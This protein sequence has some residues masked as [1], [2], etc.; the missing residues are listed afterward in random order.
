MNHFDISTNTKETE[1][2]ASSLF[3][4]MK[5]SMPEKQ[6]VFAESHRPEQWP[7]NYKVT[8]CQDVAP[9]LLEASI[10]LSGKRFRP[11]SNLAH[12][13]W[14]LP[15]PQDTSSILWQIWGERKMI[16]RNSHANISGIRTRM[17]E[18]W[19]RSH[20]SSSSAWSIGNI[21]LRAAYFS[22]FKALFRRKLSNQF[23]E[24]QHST[25]LGTFMPYR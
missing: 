15:L 21:A 11:L 8:R 19:L 6:N 20:L 10:F 4:K 12:L 22:S 2:S 25:N 1:F 23:F 18:A 13:S 9:Q 17:A 7:D 5:Q 16:F 24:F 14:F 3:N